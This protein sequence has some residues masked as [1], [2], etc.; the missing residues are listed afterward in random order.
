MFT[1]QEVIIGILCVLQ[2]DCAHTTRS[3]LALCVH[4]IAVYTLRGNS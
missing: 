2:C 4:W 3:L 1:Q